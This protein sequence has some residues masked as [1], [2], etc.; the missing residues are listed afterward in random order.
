MGNFCT[1]C[2]AKL[3]E[4]EICAC[5]QPAA[6]N[7]YEAPNSVYNQPQNTTYQATQNTTYQASSTQYYS[8]SDNRYYSASYSTTNTNANTAGK[9]PVAV[10]VLSIVSL[11]TGIIGLTFS[12]ASISGSLVFLL[13]SVAAIVTKCIAANKATIGLGKM[14]KTGFVLGI[15]GAAFNVFFF[16][17][18]FAIA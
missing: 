1:K 14:A 11:A 6:Q 5:Q 13:F 4:G 12:W 2:G 10:L 7:V 9:N 17:L 3:N 18:Y 8:P 16:L 15:I